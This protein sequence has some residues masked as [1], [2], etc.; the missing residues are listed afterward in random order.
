M[1][2]AFDLSR[3]YVHLGAGATALPIPDFEWSEAGMA[4]YRDMVGGRR[5]DDRLVCLIRQDATWETWECHPAGEEVV[6]LLSG[7]VDVIQDLPEGHHLIELHPGEALVNPTGVW[8]TARVHEPGD[9]LFITPGEGT[10]VR[11]V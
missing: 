7:R 9:A 6:V 4:R 10:E 1:S 8:H 11:P 2:N 5:D 3:T